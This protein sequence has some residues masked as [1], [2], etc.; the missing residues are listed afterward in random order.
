L[1]PLKQQ[2]KQTTKVLP[3]SFS[4]IAISTYA[5]SQILNRNLAGGRNNPIIK[6]CS[7]IEILGLRIF[8]FIGHYATCCFILFSRNQR[9]KM[10]A[11]DYSFYYLT[12]RSRST[13]LL[14]EF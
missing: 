12:G 1:V 7:L 13:H 14:I 5:D 6:K 3:E 4:C 8:S 9:L 10:I 2:S 11:L